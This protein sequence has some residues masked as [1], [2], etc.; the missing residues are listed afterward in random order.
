VSPDERPALLDHALDVVAVVDATGTVR[1]A[2]AAVERVLG[3]SPQALEGRD[4]FERVHPEDRDA[5]R[6]A[7]ATVARREGETRTVEHR[8]AD[9]DG[10]RWLESRLS[11]DG[12]KTLDGYV[13]CSRDVTDRERARSGQRELQVRLEQFAQHTD[14]ALWLFTAEFDEVLF[15][16]DAFADVYGLPA[17]RLR[18]DPTAFL[19]A[20]HPEDRARVEEAM[21]RLA[22]GGSV[23]VECRVDPE[24][25][26]RRWVWIQGEPV[27]EDGVVRRLVG[28][29]RDVTH[30]RRREQQL[31]VMDRLLRHNLR[32][33]MNVILGRARLARERGDEAIAESMETVVETGEE[34]LETADKERDI[35]NVLSNVDGPT[36]VDLSALVRDATARACDAHPDA[37]IDCRAPDGVTVTA[38]QEVELAVAELVENAVRHAEEEAPAVS[39]RVRERADRVQLT[40]RDEG[41]PIPEHEFTALTTDGEPDDLHHATGLGL[42]MVYWIVDLS[43]AE[44]DFAASEGRGNV[45]SVRF[46]NPDG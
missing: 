3:V 26:F 18:E 44:V 40:V 11:N 45:V 22:D 17:E 23:D 5:V 43:A 2:N 31:R 6:E 46:R 39:V 24:R 12:P 8:C 27:V 10:W 7:F 38:L 42:W 21:T 32:N 4:F 20:V 29:T 33:D 13:V 16:N 14:D 25:D 9:G 15:V 37:T 35:V 1:Y 34:L 28:F 36:E 41:P 19:D 30:R